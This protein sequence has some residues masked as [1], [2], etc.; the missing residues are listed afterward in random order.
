MGLVAVE[1]PVAGVIGEKVECSDG[2][3]RHVSRRLG[4][5]RAFRHPSEDGTVAPGE[6]I[7]CRNAGAAILKAEILARIQGNVGAIAFSRTADPD[8][9]KFEDAV[10]LK[11][12]GEVPSDLTMLF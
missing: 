9:G 7:E 1:C 4:P 3:D 12:F 11:K 8:V 10:V 5:L 6:A 2:T